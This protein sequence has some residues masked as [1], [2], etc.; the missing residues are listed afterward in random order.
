[1]SFWDKFRSIFQV[2]DTPHRIAIAFA[3]GVFWGISPLVGLHT[4]G[5]FSFAWL[6]RLNRLVAVVGVYITNPWTVVP[7]YSFCLWVGIKLVGMK[8]A[9][10]EVDWKNL[11]FMYMVHKLTPLLWPFIVGTFV[12]ATVSGIISYFIIYNAALRYRKIKHV[13]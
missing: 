4:I 7:I 10:P 6:F 5:A 11:T 8:Q 3:L 12:V 9:L 2:N 13:T 1:M